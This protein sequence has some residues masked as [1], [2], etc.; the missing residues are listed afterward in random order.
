[1][2][3]N[4]E[5]TYLFLKGNKNKLVF[6]PPDDVITTDFTLMMRFTPDKDY[7][8]EGIK[9]E[10]FFTQGLFSKNGKHIG[11]FFTAGKDEIN[12]ILL[13]VSFEWWKK[14]DN[15]DVDEVKSIDFYPSIEEVE[16]GLDVVVIKNKNSIELIV[17]GKTKTAEMKDVIDY[18]YSYTWVGCA[19]RLSP[20]YQHIFEGEINLLHLQEKVLDS[21]NINLFFNDYNKFVKEVSQ[22][23]NNTIMFT[24]NFEE[25]SPY[26]VKDHS[27]NNNHLI[28]FSKQW[29]N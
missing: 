10:P 5:N 21:D 27:Y 15:P 9:K 17:N 7:Y 24:S 12:N 1:M 6:N 16:K 4:K 29:L 19:N 14:T 2:K 22:N 8:L 25:V 20:E 23:M 3:I 18:S 13:K 28:K 26:K 11:L